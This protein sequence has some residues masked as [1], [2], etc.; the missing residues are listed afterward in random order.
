VLQDTVEDFIE[1]P[2]FLKKRRPHQ[3]SRGQDFAGKMAREAPGESVL[4]GSL[5][6]M[7]VMDL[8]QSLDMV[9]RPAALT[10]S[11]GAEKC[12]MF[13]RTARSTTLSTAALKATRPST[14]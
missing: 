14:R 1:K 4:R 13:L 5:A 10:L 3:E 11:N 7:N 12:Q 2:F 6:Q 9:T 8:L